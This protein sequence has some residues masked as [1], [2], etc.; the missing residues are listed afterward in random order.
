MLSKEHGGQ[1]A[2]ELAIYLLLSLF[3][4]MVQQEGCIESRLFVGI[5]L[6]EERDINNILTTPQDSQYWSVGL[7]KHTVFSYSD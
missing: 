1:E 5:T 7:S 2:S 6:L 4:G 3:V